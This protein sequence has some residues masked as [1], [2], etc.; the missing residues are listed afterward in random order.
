MNTGFR[1]VLP[2]YDISGCASDF[3]HNFKHLMP[4]T[5]NYGATK[6]FTLTQIGSYATYPEV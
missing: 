6:F 5:L 2:M 1:G 4:N 3:A